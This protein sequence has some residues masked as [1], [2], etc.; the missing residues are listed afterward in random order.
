MNCF[1]LVRNRNRRN[2]LDQRT[3]EGPSDCL[4]D[5][6]HQRLDILRKLIEQHVPELAVEAG[7]AEQKSEL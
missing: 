1:E 5:G 4:V 2:D 7:T 3:L 6:L